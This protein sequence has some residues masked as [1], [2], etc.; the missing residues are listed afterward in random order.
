MTAPPDELTLF[1]AD[2]A[3]EPTPGA[4]GYQAANT[5][6]CAGALAGDGYGWLGRL[7][8]APVAL[9]CPR[10]RRP[11]RLG[12]VPLLWECAPCDARDE[13]RNHA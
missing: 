11:M 4:V 12:A 8:P 3:P 5:V 2:T 13:G 6:T 1:D 9:P 10:C 7:L